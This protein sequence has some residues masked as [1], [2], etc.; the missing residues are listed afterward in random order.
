[1][2]NNNLL[3]IFIKNINLPVCTECIHFRYSKDLNNIHGLCAKFGNKNI[4]NNK[5]KFNNVL[6]AR[7][8][9]CGIKARYYEPHNYNKNL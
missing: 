5:I 2:S 9:L 3:K 1:M 4:I 8:K 6:Y 7:K